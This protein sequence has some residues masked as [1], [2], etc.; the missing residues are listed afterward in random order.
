MSLKLT[1]PRTYSIR[2]RLYLSLGATLAIVLVVLVYFFSRYAEEAAERSHD[3]LL[4]ASALTMAGSMRLDGGRLSA[5]M[6]FAAFAILASARGDRVFYRLIDDEEHTITGYPDLPMPKTFGSGSDQQ[7]YNTVM[8]GFSVRA[9]AMR[10]LLS[11]GERARWA[12]ILVAQTTATRDG[13]AAEIVQHALLALLVLAAIAATMLWITVTN[14][15]RPISSLKAHI[16]MRA[17]TDFRP[18]DLPLPD[19]IRPLGQALDNLLQRFETSLK[20]TRMFLADAAHQLRT[21]LASVL[22]NAELSLKEDNPALRAESL[23]RVHRNARLAGRIADQLLAEATVSNRLE[24][25]PRQPV[26]PARMAMEIVNDFAGAPDRRIIRL[27][28]ADH[29]ESLEIPGDPG[30]LGEALRNLIDNAIKYSPAN[31]PVDV[32]I[33]RG[34]ETA[35]GPTVIVAVEDRGEGIPVADRQSVLQRFHRGTRPQRAPGS[36]L[37]LS[38]VAQVV[39]GH[40]GRIALADRDGGGLRAEMQFPAQDPEAIP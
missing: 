7:F 9:V 5:D 33:E 10:R 29:A 40:G 12:T 28:V 13:L 37:G 1:S 22:N 31:G 2:R 3:Q 36:G 35:A 11:S 19:E 25:A 21:P 26:N 23:A 20:Q 34:K 17:S 15:L 18:L 14:T 4:A 8:R 27:H 39:A 30:A 32:R 16:D 24:L 6:P 38:I